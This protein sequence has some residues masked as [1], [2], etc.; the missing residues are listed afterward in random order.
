MASVSLD[1]VW[2]SSASDLTDNL[3]TDSLATLT[4]A[5]VTQGTVRLYAN[6]RTRAIA[7]AGKSQHASV[8]ILACSRADIAWIE[9]HAGVLV[10]V[11]DPLGRKFYGIYYAPTIIERPVELTADVALDLTEVTH[12]ETA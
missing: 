12:S 9:A 1:T 7:Q 11:R 10:L 5:P 8:Q 3:A 2:L 4:L 6:G